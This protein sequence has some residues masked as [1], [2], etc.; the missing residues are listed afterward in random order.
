[1]SL[2]IEWFTA[3]QATFPLSKPARDS[4]K[5]SKVAREGR[6]D[7]NQSLP[8]C[9]L[10]STISLFATLYNKCV[11]SSPQVCSK[12]LTTGK[13][14]HRVPCQELI[15]FLVWLL[16]MSTVDVRTD[17]SAVLS[18]SRLLEGGDQF[19]Y[20]E[21]NMGWVVWGCGWGAWFSNIPQALF[22]I[23]H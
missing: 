20:R 21:Q 13:L 10:G 12:L 9:H 14:S 16:L 4:S 5:P 6:W 22:L 1:M 3:R 23:P 11:V 8:W 19:F 17:I 15:L 18:Q 7:G 2:W